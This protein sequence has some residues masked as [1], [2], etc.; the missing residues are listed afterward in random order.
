MSITYWA[1]LA[2]TSLGLL[3]T[4]AVLSYILGDNPLFRIAIHLFI[5]VSAG[6]ALLFVVFNVLIYQLILPILRNPTGSLVEAL[7]LLLGVGLW[8]AKISPRTA[9][10]GNPLL[11]YLVGV[12]AATAIG[13]AVVG[14]VLPQISASTEVFKTNDILQASAILIGTLTTLA[15]FHFGGRA[16]AGQTFRRPPWVEALGLVGQVFVAITLGAIFAGIYVAALT[17]LIE[18]SYA[19][20]EAVRTIL[21]ALQ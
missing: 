15:Y 8:L 4:V 9:R 2:G 10:L 16:A 20:L 14:T 12:G 21:K 6:F 5:G 11:G 13:G 17:A 1:E 19:I 7:L 3:L 18:R